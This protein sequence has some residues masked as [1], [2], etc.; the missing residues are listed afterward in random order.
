VIGCYQPTIEEDEVTSA[1]DSGGSSEHNDL[2]T[3]PT[4]SAATGSN[5][6]PQKSE[7]D[8][9]FDACPEDTYVLLEDENGTTYI[10]VISVFC[11]PIQNINL[12]CPAP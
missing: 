8:E 4:S 11:E 9:G 3:P 5:L 1:A 10:V 6:P 7:E 2:P 12:G